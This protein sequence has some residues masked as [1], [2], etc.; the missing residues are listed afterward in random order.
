M[1]GLLSLH[2]ISPLP[3]H[4]LLAQVSVSVH[5]FPSVQLPEVAEFVQP[6]CALQ[7]SA[8]QGLP[9]SQLIS[10][11]P[12]HMPPEHRSIGVHWFPSSQ[13]KLASWKSQPVTGLQKSIVQS[14]LSLH[15]NA[16][17]PTQSPF[18]QVSVG[19]HTLPSVHEPSLGMLT[20]PRVLSQVSAVHGLLSSQAICPAPLQIP[21]M[22]WSTVVH[23]LP[24]SHSATA[25]S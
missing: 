13:G 21:A 8:V 17:L 9:S 19:V 6:C 11:V 25:F 14:L 16:P 1:Q 4:C 10:P 18:T 12:T 5:T 2:C 24:S 3:T 20:Q 15:A 22:H 7:A 23:S